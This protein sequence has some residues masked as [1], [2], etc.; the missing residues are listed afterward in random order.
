MRR[1]VDQAVVARERHIT[2]SFAARSA[3]PRQ[4]G[5]TQLSDFWH[6]TRGGDGAKTT[7]RSES[8][9]A[10]QRRYGGE[11]AAQAGRSWRAGSLAASCCPALS[12]AVSVKSWVVPG[13]GSSGSS[14]R[15]LACSAGAVPVRSRGAGSAHGRGSHRTCAGTAARPRRGSA[16]GAACN[17]S[18]AVEHLEDVFPAI[19]K[20]VRMISAKSDHCRR[21]QRILWMNVE[22]WINAVRTQERKDFRPDSPDVTGEDEAFGVQCTCR[23]SAMLISRP[24]RMRTA[25]RPRWRQR[26]AAR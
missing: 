12:V 20:H 4:S 18:I 15:L 25:Q 23:R 16:A 22:L 24:R 21:L 1:P 26:A 2:T 13:R 10:G 7:D 11:L 9:R 5:I 14:R 17:N 6:G 3:A 8:T 19:R